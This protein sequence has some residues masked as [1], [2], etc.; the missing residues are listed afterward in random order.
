LR[1]AIRG[2]I[3][4][5]WA[6]ASVSVSLAFGGIMGTIGKLTTVFSIAA[7]VAVSSLAAQS[8]NTFTVAA[9]NIE[10]WVLMDRNGKPDQPKPTSK[11][12]AVFGIVAKV[13][14]DVL[15]VEEMGMTNELAELITG[16]RARGVDFAYHEW[17]QGVD[18]NRHVSLLSRYPIVKRYSRT[19]YS[20]LLNGKPQRIERGILDVKVKVNDQY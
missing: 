1:F 17:I 15:S 12:E 20:Y 2:K 16:L 3:L 14:P 4:L 8:T 9:Y 5:A 19:D 11:K 7:L 18:T 13:R 10:N 6:S